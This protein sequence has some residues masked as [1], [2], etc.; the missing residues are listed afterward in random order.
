MNG[1]PPS[2]P[3]AFCGSTLEELSFGRCW[4]RM[5]GQLLWPCHS[6]TLPFNNL[7]IIVRITIG[8][9]MCCPNMYILCFYHYAACTHACTYVHMSLA[10]WP[11]AN[12]QWLRPLNQK[13]Y[14]STNSLLNFRHGWGNRDSPQHGTPMNIHIT[15]VVHKYADITTV[16]PCMGYS[17]DSNW[18]TLAAV[19][20]W[21]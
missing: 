14:A 15:Y 4:A 9:Y 10:A 16:I 13:M 18:D 7:S 5:A 11:L 6:L 8:P 20:D 12:F 2:P 21:S 1:Q 17:R 19:L 3:N